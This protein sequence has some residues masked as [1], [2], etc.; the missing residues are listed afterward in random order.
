[1]TEMEENI[2][3]RMWTLSGSLPVP[4]NWKHQPDCEA[5]CSEPCS[6]ALPPFTKRLHGSTCVYAQGDSHT[7]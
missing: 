7:V 3:M 2:K 5:N 1:M 6:G 4:S